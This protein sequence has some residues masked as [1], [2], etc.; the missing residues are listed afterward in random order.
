VRTPSDPLLATEEEQ[1][2][3]AVVE[4]A[5]PFFELGGCGGR[6]ASTSLPYTRHDATELPPRGLV[7][8]VVVITRVEQRQVSRFR[9]EGIKFGRQLRL[10]R[11]DGTH[12]A[13]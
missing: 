7:L 10:K 11:R 9:S 5:L 8:R 4:F 6:M 13:P 2:R 12:A 1:R 3:S